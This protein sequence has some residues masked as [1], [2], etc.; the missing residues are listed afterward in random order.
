[1][2]E[3]LARAFMKSVPRH[4]RHARFSTGTLPLWR[5]AQEVGGTEAAA[6]S[7]LG[8]HWAVWS[9]FLGPD[10]AKHITS[11]DIAGMVVESL[12]PSDARAM[13]IRLKDTEWYLGVVQ[14]RPEI[15]EHWAVFLKSIPS[16]F[17]IFEDSLYLFHRGYELEVEDTRDYVEYREWEASGLFPSIYWEDSGA[18]ETIFDP[19][20]NMQHFRRLGEADELLHGQFSSAL[21]ETLMRCSDLD[22]NLTQ[23]LHAALKAFDGHET[24]EELAHVSLSCRRFTEKLAD[25]LYLPR[26]EKVNGRKVGQAEYR[27]RLWAYIAENVTS[28][29]TRELLIANV[30]DLGKRIDRLDSLSNKGLHSD[31]SSSDVNRLLLSLLVVA[32]DLISLRPPSGAFSYKPYETAIRVFMEKVLH[33]EERLSQDAE[34]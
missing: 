17:R 28:D 16:R 26:E 3:S 18:R 11:F 14:V 29:T 22:P 9:T 10:L 33:Q 2:R 7:V 4:R 20:D 21:G 5:L 13:H 25:C 6:N 8:E 30:E 32:H 12:T 34:E 1:M 31:V 27:N 23:R 15:P 24:A 19:F